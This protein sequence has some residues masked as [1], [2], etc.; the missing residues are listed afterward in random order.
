MSDPLL[1]SSN[2]LVVTRTRNTRPAN[3]FELTK[4]NNQTMA[5]MTCLLLAD[6]KEYF[7]ELKTDQN[8]M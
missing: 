7:L 6:L 8:P 1:P 5:K 2:G 3:I 4:C